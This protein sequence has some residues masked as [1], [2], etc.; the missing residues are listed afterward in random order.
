ME[1]DVPPDAEAPRRRPT[2]RAARG[3]LRTVVVLIAAVAIGN[4]A[5]LGLSMWARSATTS[6]SLE[7][8]GVDNG[9]VVDGRVW[10]GAAPTGDGYRQLVEAGVTTVVDLRSDSERGVA[11]DVLP[12]LDVEVV[13]IP[14]RDGQLPT[15]VEVARFVEVV[16]ESDGTVFVHCGAGVGRTGAMAAAYQA[17]VGGAGGLESV[18]RNL[19]VGPPSLEQ[20]AFAASGGDRPGPVLTAVSRVLDSPRRI[21]HNIT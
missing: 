16:A 13:R 10:R 5:I 8:P 11:V 1:P 19:A 2:R 21:W 9:Y 6:V 12:E 15:D 7:V 17:A 4:L 14:I 20:I 3:T 18:R